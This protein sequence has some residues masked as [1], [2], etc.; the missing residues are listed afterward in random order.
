MRADEL[1]CVGPTA[2]A[3]RPPTPLPLP[4]GNK[5]KEQ[6][7]QKKTKH[8]SFGTILL[9]FFTVVCGFHFENN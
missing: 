7:Q 8:A 9:L 3:L 5:L 2:Q 4:G 6:Q 1:L